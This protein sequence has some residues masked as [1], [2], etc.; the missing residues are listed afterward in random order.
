MKNKIVLMQL[1]LG[2]IPDY[3]WF[4]YE[5]TKNLNIDFLIFTD[6]GLVVDSP[7]YK[8][9]PITKDEVEDKVS[10]MLNHDY[11][12]IN[13]QK[14]SD[15]KSCLGE[16]FED[17]L[18]GYDFF[19]FYDIDTL[20]GDFQK[21]VIP[22]TEEYDVISFAD[23]DYHNRVSGPFTIIKNTYENKR[24]YRKSLG[25][26][27]EI[28]NFDYVTA[29]DEHEMS[30]ILIENCKVKLIYDSINCETQNG[31]KNTYDAYWSGGKVY[32][33]NEEK[34]LYHFYRKNKTKL[35]KV[36]NLIT[37]SYDKAI[38]DDFYWVVSFTKSYEALFINLLESI[39]K[40]S[41]RKCIIYSINYDYFLSKHDLSNE[42]FIVRKID[43]PEG[44]KDVRGR[45]NNIISSK[46][47][48]NVDLI[49]SFPDKKF[50]C[51][52]SDIYFTVNSDNIKKHFN[53]LENY[54][55]IN[56]HIHDVFY[57]SNIIEGE[58]WTSSLHILKN[59]MG[60]TTEIFPRRKTNVMIF[61][62]NSEWFFKEQM[63]IYQK[64][65]GT[66]PGIL[67]FH[68]EDTA[69]AVL[70]KYNL[71]KGLP[72]LDIEEV[73]DI[74]M[75]IFENYSY[76]M[77]DISSS[78]VLPKNHNEVLFFHGI[79][80]Q[81]HY[82]NIK[83]NYNVSVIDCEEIVTTYSNQTLVFEK[84]SFMTTKKVGEVVD[85]VIGDLDGNEIFRLGNQYFYNYWYFY[86]TNLFLEPKKYSIKIYETNTNKCIFNDI[87]EVKS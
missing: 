74:D 42:Q 78:V 83:G 36:G 43:I 45:D 56:S 64:Y 38:V 59:E 1:W 50:V 30:Q 41:N 82:D 24:L 11:K 72:L 63:E 39:K 61:D 37:A 10:L 7:N 31:G 81:E 23:K 28:L 66:K 33:E 32:I 48:I 51:I 69:N 13:P 4:H 85:F 44:D 60:V 25:R 77:T 52:D 22:Y 68:D 18:I 26:F 20:F 53:E 12:I 15:L 19:G 67:L 40:Y 46:P 86:V 73:T 29:F 17:Y 75:G 79:K 47:S 76:S 49:N 80:S 14:I 70:A 16:L 62:S 71:T 34:S 84:N 55:L 54:P 58:E 5:T 9:I 3:F 65:K 2:K 27:I 57:L 35:N 8:V 87:L 21:W 6:S